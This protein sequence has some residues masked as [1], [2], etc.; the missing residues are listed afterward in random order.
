MHQKKLL[1]FVGLILLYSNAVFS[2]SLEE[3]KTHVRTWNRFADQTL[4]LHNKLIDELPVKRE[5]D[6]GGYAHLPDF[7]Q[8]ESYYHNGKLISR[9]QRESETGKPHVI[10]VFIRDDQ[11][12]VVRDYTAAYLPEYHNAPTQ[13]LVS[14][15]AYNGELHAFRSFDASGELVVE[16]CTGTLEGKEVNLLQDLDQ[17]FQA[18]QLDEELQQTREYRRCFE[19]LPR[20]PGKYLRPTGLSGKG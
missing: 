18:A 2:Q 11:G 14:L 3:D 6:S 10:E 4:A 5:T 7:Y 12:R 17:I 9:L 19:G 1:L 16:R 20:E 13:T 15:H 8:E